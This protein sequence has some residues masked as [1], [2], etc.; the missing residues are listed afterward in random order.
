MLN[1]LSNDTQHD[2]S[3][4]SSG[5]ASG[6]PSSTSPAK[7]GSLLQE[8]H[9]DDPIKLASLSLTLMQANAWEALEAMSSVFLKERIMSLDSHTI[10]DKFPLYVWPVATTGQLQKGVMQGHDDMSHLLRGLVSGFDPMEDWRHMQVYYRVWDAETT[11][12]AVRLSTSSGLIGSSFPGGVVILYKTGADNW[13][14]HDLKVVKN[15]NQEYSST[16]FATIEQATAAYK[17]RVSLSGAPKSWD[18]QLP[19]NDEDREYW[20]S[21]DTVHLKTTST[22]S[23]KAPSLSLEESTL[24]EDE[25]DDYWGEYDDSVLPAY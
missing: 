5:M 7:M 13:S 8:S 2:P 10:T 14:Y 15:W 4:G 11:H 20:S 19:L 6:I 23:K 12:A 3:M 16:W 25:D 22:P 9:F 18:A 21:Y 1:V 24:K 17:D